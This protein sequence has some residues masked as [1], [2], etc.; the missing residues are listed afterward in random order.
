M[1]TAA[2]QHEAL[3]LRNGDRSYANIGIA[4]GATADEVRDA[5]IPGWRD[6]PIAR[7]RYAP[8]AAE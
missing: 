8:R 6:K 2:Q 1:L 5:L 4:I 7:G 3:R